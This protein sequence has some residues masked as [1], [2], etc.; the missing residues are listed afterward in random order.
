M[1]DGDRLEC[2]IKIHKVRFYN[3]D[4]GFGI[5]T[6]DV[7]QITSGTPV[8]D[9]WNRLVAKGNM[10]EPK[11]GRTYKFTGIE[12]VD[13][14]WGPQYKILSLITPLALEDASPEEQ[15]EFLLSIFTIGQVASMYE[16]LENPY[17][18][19]WNKD[20]KELVKV[21]GC[22]MKTAAMWINR[23]HKHIRMA[24][25]VLSLKDYDITYNMAAKLLNNYHQSSDLVIER[26]T[27]NPYL[28]MEIDG[29][30]WKKCD[31]LA[32]K[33]GM[34]PYSPLRVSAYMTYYLETMAQ[35]G[36]TYV[37]SNS[38][39]MESLLA[40]FGEDIPD[41]PITEAIHLLEKKL[42]WSE[43]H[44]KVGL[45]KHIR[46]EERIAE[47]LLRLKNSKSKI[48]VNDWRK[49]I[50]D[51][52]EQQGWKYTDEQLS[53]IQSAIDENVILITGYAGTGKSSVVSAILK[54]LPEYSF[55]QCALA[56]RAAA[57]LS[58]IT[59]AD[60]YTIHR[61]LGYPAGTH[62]GFEYFEYIENGKVIGNYLPYEIIILD[63]VSMV[64]S[65]LFLSLI[66][67]ISPGSK[68]IMLGDI[69]QLESIGC[70]NVA[71]DIIVSPEIISVQLTKIHRQA[72]TSAIITDSVKV[73]Y[74]EQLIP[75]DWTGEETRGELQDLTYH[76][77]LDVN[78]TFYKVMQQMSALL[79]EDINIMDIQV[80][81]PMK[82]RGGASTWNLNLAIQEL[83]NPLKDNDQEIIIK[84]PGKDTTYSLRLGDKVINTQNNYQTN[85][86]VESSDVIRPLEEEDGSQKKIGNCPIYNGNIGI[87][88][89][90]DVKQR[91]IVVDFYD[92]GEVEIKSESLSA[93]QLGYAITC[94]KMQGDQC[95][96]VIVAI[97]FSAYALLTKELIYTAMTRAIKH[98]WIIAQTS[99]LRYA[100]AQNGVSKK[101]TMLVELLH[102]I[103]HPKMVF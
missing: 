36:Y 88:T 50:Q 5:I 84:A 102:N 26:V 30:G 1:A 37:Y 23:F 91:S 83:Y 54:A 100:V 99:A 7:S 9:K 10:P 42:W 28:L 20:A 64:D 74:N 55:A 94:H 35:N 32:L 73:R 77:Y 29:Y 49:T 78:N 90:I 14:K 57:R 41:E 75:K 48:Q 31:A 56:G 93:I 44:E 69:G 11:V 25:V 43:D 81:T 76:C 62:N 97:D 53:A 80:I 47:K 68:L 3:A 39:L 72:K 13:P 96:Y 85:R 45:H 51:L 103:A 4:T 89:K 95:K 59:H 38:Q 60:G 15:K 17:K 79:A 86:Y 33:G 46:T 67:A 63:E 21:Y 24:K 27:K 18:V 34:H 61:L 65:D 8:Y 82:D 98:C 16:A 87:I 101:Q 12:T 66:Q 40:T 70:G 58:E 22:G 6:A 19:L 71:H 52:E 2:T 92:I